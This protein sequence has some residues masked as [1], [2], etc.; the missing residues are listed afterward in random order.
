MTWCVPYLAAACWQSSF[1]VGTCNWLFMTDHR[2]LFSRN[3]LR[4]FSNRWNSSRR[5]RRV[6]RGKDR[7]FL[8]RFSKLLRNHCFLSPCKVGLICDTFEL[9]IDYFVS[10]GLPWYTLCVWAV[11]RLESGSSKCT[12]QI[13]SP[14]HKWSLRLLR[15]PI[16]SVI[17][18]NV[19]FDSLVCCLDR[20][21]DILFL[22]LRLH[23]LP[24]GV[25]LLDLEDASKLPSFVF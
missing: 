8:F 7:T 20:T 25:P 4:S 22:R 14:S 3:R 5:S 2:S 12:L 24:L 10:L 23:P 18:V 17:S 13:S 9:L 19:G 21:W 1:R 11:L 16:C 6:I 15:V